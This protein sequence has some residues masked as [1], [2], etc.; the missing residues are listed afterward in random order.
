MMCGPSGIA[1]EAG[2][3][4]AFLLTF[5]RA[6]HMLTDIARR[7]VMRPGILPDTECERMNVSL[8]PPPVAVSNFGRCNVRAVAIVFMALG[9]LSMPPTAAAQ[10]S[11][12]INAAASNI[13]ALFRKSQ[14]GP[15]ASRCSDEDFVRRVHLD[16][17]GMIPTAQQVRD[18][19]SDP[20]TDKRTALIDR[21]LAAP[22][23][24]RNMAYVLDVWL[25]ERRSD[26][27][28]SREQWLEYLFQSFASRKPYN[29]L[30]RELLAADGAG[31]ERVRA[32]FL[33]DRQCDPHAIVRDVGRM[34]LG[35]D[36][37]CAQCHDHPLVDD[38][39]QRD[40]HGLLALTQRTYLFT[41]KKNGD[42]VLVG[43]RAEGVPEYKSV[44][45][46]HEEQ[47]LAIAHVP[48][49]MPVEIPTV[50]L[51]KEYVVAPA[52]DARAVPAFSLR[53][54]LATHVTVDN[55]AFD[56]NAVNRFWSHLCGSGLVHPIDM[57]HSDNRVA[58]PEV[59]GYLANLFREMQYDVRELLAVV[60]RTA[61]YQR[62][63]DPPPLQDVVDHQ[64][65]IVESK[66][67][68]ASQLEEFE[69]AASD[70]DTQW[71]TARSALVDA[72]DA[73]EKAMRTVQESRTKTAQ[74]SA[75]IGKLRSE[76]E[77][78][79]K[80]FAEQQ[81][82][83]QAVEAAT[84]QAATALEQL[85][86][87]DEL[88]A[89]LETLKKKQAT[90]TEALQPIAEK[91]NSLKEQIDIAEQTRVALVADLEHSQQH[92]RDAFQPLAAAYAN[93][94]Q[95]DRRRDDAKAMR[96]W[97]KSQWELVEQ[98]Q[99][100]TELA[101][102]ADSQEGELEQAYEKV[103]G[104]WCDA[105][106]VAR[107][108]PLTPEQLAWSFWQ[109]TGQVQF[110]QQAVVDEWLKGHPAPRN[111]DPTSQMQRDEALQRDQQ[112]MLT[113]RM[114]GTVK[115]FATLFGGAA[116]QVQTDFY[117]SPDQALFLANGGQVLNALNARDHNLTD[118][119]Q[120]AENT[121]AFADE[122]FVS[123]LSRRA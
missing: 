95:C 85:G 6:W 111:L 105:G 71:E 30:V 12:D 32:K 41:D 78:L 75:E 66:S 91:R 69:A 59:L 50:E 80:G 33:L 10:T 4:A 112:R 74:K 94:L 68:L 2:Q 84:T 88:A 113:S 81:P 63:I 76:L 54:E 86:G 103:V 62:S 40:Y 109:A 83:L 104:A 97:T 36:L 116:G 42:M 43:E 99:Q 82:K 25:M 87:D 56:R 119:L 49:G 24:S 11:M 120:H 19:L 121:E 47:V 98:L 51:G 9:C 45:M 77:P 52:D 53:M 35:R 31:N 13:D 18:F 14:V 114:E 108:R 93:W 38:Y 64:G 34:F 102:K 29:Q 90:L 27:G 123:V 21:L 57:H 39:Y 117:A 48:G 73:V 70:C 100:L 44:F 8:T 89:V 28:I 23:F 110:E 67:R 61:A 101:G 60:T 55:V 72:E 58:H 16:L 115:Q 118:R 65:D 107:P 37:Q 20:S 3:D 46:P 5:V 15:G 79:E 26:N 1:G 122:L 22:E 106:A 96:L 17:W 92:L 7:Q